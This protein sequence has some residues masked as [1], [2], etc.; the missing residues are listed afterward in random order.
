VPTRDVLGNVV[1][2]QNQAL[3]GRTY[4]PQPLIG[5]AAPVI[6]TN[7]SLPDGYVTLPYQW[8]QTFSRI[9]T[10]TLTSGSLPPGLAITQ[11]M[12]TQVLISGTP[13]TVGTYTFTLH[14]V[15]GGAFE[16]Y[17]YQIRI[18]ASPIGGSSF[19]GGF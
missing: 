3:V 14:Y 18:D 7:T 12:N 6:P 5:G 13:T 11:P 4:V 1:T 2:I 15:S 10:A 8:L 17:N 9:T 16:D 19:V